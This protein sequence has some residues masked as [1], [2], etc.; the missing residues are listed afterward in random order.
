MPPIIYRMTAYEYTHNLDKKAKFMLEHLEKQFRISK[1]VIDK[2]WVN[3]TFETMSADNL[4]T[5]ANF[6]QLTQRHFTEYMDGKKTTKMMGDYWSSVDGKSVR[7]KRA[8]HNYGT[9]DDESQYDQSG[10]CHLWDDKEGGKFYYREYDITPEYF[11]I[12]CNGTFILNEKVLERMRKGTKTA[13]LKKIGLYEPEKPEKPDDKLISTAN[14]LNEI[15]DKS[16]CCLCPGK[17]TEWGH[18]PAPLKHDEGAK[19]CDTCNL[20]KVLPARVSLIQ[21]PCKGSCDSCSDAIGLFKPLDRT[22]CEL[23]EAPKP[24]EPVKPKKVIKK[25]PTMS[26]EAINEAKAMG[27]DVSGVKVAKK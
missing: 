16:K 5:F 12:D 2:E 14:M 18:N 25:K 11:T 7:E 24:V 9:E 22:A 10:D 26:Q 23:Y 20:H 3:A 8:F 1:Q 19:C 27:L 17:Y 13:Y 21:S 4:W 15:A 6:Y